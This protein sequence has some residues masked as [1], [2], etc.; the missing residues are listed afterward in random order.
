MAAPAIGGAALGAAA[1]APPLGAGHEPSAL[2]SAMRVHVAEYAV[3][4][5]PMAVVAQLAPG[6]PPAAVA[7]RD[8]LVA[9]AALDQQ[10]EK[11]RRR[12]ELRLL[13]FDSSAEVDIAAVRAALD[14][15]P[16]GALGATG[17]LLGLSFGPIPFARSEQSEEHVADAITAFQKESRAMLGAALVRHRAE[18][19]VRARDLA[20]CAAAGAGAAAEARAADALVVKALE[21]IG[22][23]KGAPAAA[24][25]AAAQAATLAQLAIAVTHLGNEQSLW[26][27]AAS[28]ADNSVVFRAG[29]VELLLTAAGHTA[30]ARAGGGRSGGGAGDT[31]EGA[32][33]SV[34]AGVLDLAR[35][36]EDAIETGRVTLPATPAKWLSVN[37]SS[38]EPT[39]ANVTR[40]AGSTPISQIIPG[41][42]TAAMIFGAKTLQLSG[43]QFT[44][45]RAGRETIA[46][47][48]DAGVA[49][50][51]DA[52]PQAADALMLGDPRVVAEATASVSFTRTSALGAIARSEYPAGGK[53]DISGH[54]RF[55]AQLGVIVDAI[56]ID[57]LRELA[58][59]ANVRAD[60]HEVNKRGLL[61]AASRIAKNLDE[62]TGTAAAAAAAAGVTAP[63]LPPA[64]ALVMVQGALAELLSASYDDA[65]TE[66]GKAFTAAGGGAPGL[67]AAAA[68]GPSGFAALRIN[69]TMA[70]EAARTRGASLQPFLSAYIASATRGGGSAS[71]KRAGGWRPDSAGGR[72]DVFQGVG[73]DGADAAWWARHLSRTFR[74]PGD[75]SDGGGSAAGD[76]GAGAHMLRAVQGGLAVRRPGGGSGGCGVREEP[77]F[78]PHLGGEARSIEGG[79]RVE[80]G[81]VG[82]HGEWA[83]GERGSVSRARPRLPARSRLLSTFVLLAAAASAAGSLADAR[84]G[85]FHA[86]GFAG[87][88]SAGT[89]GAHASDSIPVAGNRAG[90]VPASVH[91]VDAARV[92]DRRTGEPGGAAAR[93]VPARGTCGIPAGS[94]GGIPV[95][96]FV[97]GIPGDGAVGS[98]PASSAT[99]VAGIPCDGAV[100]S[101]PAAS[102]TFVA[103]IPCDGAVGS[104]PASSATFV[105]GIPGD[106]G[107]SDARVA[108]GPPRAGDACV[109]VSVA[110]R[111]ALAAV[112][113]RARP[114]SEVARSIAAQRRR[115]NRHG[116]L[117]VLKF[118]SRDP[119][120]RY[121]LRPIDAPAFVAPAPGEFDAARHDQL[122][123]G[124]VVAAIETVAAR[125]VLSAHDLVC[126]MTAA[127]TWGPTPGARA[128]VKGAVPVA[129][130]LHADVVY[131]MARADPAALPPG[132]SAEMLRDAVS[133]GGDAMYT[134]VRRHATTHNSSPPSA[135]AA[136]Q[137][138]SGHDA[139]VAGGWVLDVTEIVVACPLMPLILS[140]IR[141]VPKAF[142]DDGVTATSWRPISVA[143]GMPG[144]G[145][146]WGV[147]PSALHPVPLD[148]MADVA[149][150]IHRV[151]SSAGGEPV[152]IG[153]FDYAKA[154]RQFA[155]RVDDLWLHC[156]CLD[157]RVYA[158]MRIAF[159]SRAGGQWLCAVTHLV[160]RSVSRELG[161]DGA[162]V[163]FVDDSGIVV[164]ESEFPRAEALFRAAAARVGLTINE[165]KVLPPATRQRFIGP[166]WCTETMRIYLPAAK[167]TLLCSDLEAAAAA[168]TLRCRD[169]LS[170]LQRM[171]WASQ[172]VLVLASCQAPI[173]ALIRAQPMEARLP[174]TPECRE[175]LLACVDM[176]RSCNGSSVV[177][178]AELLAHAPS[179]Y[180]DASTWGFGWM[181]YE[182][183]RYASEP[184]PAGSA[185]AAA[186][187]NALELPAASAAMIDLVTQRAAAGI[188]TPAVHVFCDNTAACACI[189]SLG[190]SSLMLATGTHAL[191]SAA[192]SLDFVPLST[193]VQSAANPADAPSRGEIPLELAG[194]T[195]VR[196]APAAVAQWAAPSAWQCLRS[197]PPA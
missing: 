177:P 29:A 124:G 3:F 153:A 110:D 31:S 89:T 88:V 68:L 43:A 154:Y 164:V 144:V 59:I 181:C 183:R 83:A 184:W 132:L 155:N 36:R 53:G 13:D 119:A 108:G 101:I 99:F 87:L 46:R 92:G 81:A 129:S 113:P 135:A 174:I 32:S 5:V 128:P 120:H 139:D 6:A 143:S 74:A 150:A 140:G 173:R 131:E 84:G 62:S 21:A 125:G 27:V 167:T 175:A 186:H 169:L 156:Y 16:D 106:S 86:S 127:F 76:A 103:G 141:Q 49:R 182:T 115:L 50:Y 82:R 133:H 10:A 176:L 66:C 7:A 79:D 146:N 33:S 1:V 77:A 60:A 170:L 96:P 55:V 148:T 147:D 67:A 158:D 14:L 70:E 4:N 93:G 130:P 196:Y 52:H 80:G 159:G 11:E 54:H 179:T 142:A 193:W 22:V 30:V 24:V 117:A 105:D 107:T 26:A 40:P 28:R 64:L 134:G 151:V 138:R 172:M 39:A 35:V 2:C 95:L 136:A 171:Q 47:D 58:G 97:D 65:L 34:S 42:V 90:G 190:T 102:A 75:R 178:R 111:A 19:L 104:F 18:R 192:A 57:A 15:V 121:E 91:C 63:P 197:S 20:A 37:L 73:P 126:A 161:A 45:G 194:W 98:I 145:S 51:L 8:L 180:S 165:D 118:P 188:P 25:T 168:R 191:A 189:S 48:I 41:A 112:L 23:L 116:H 9:Q 187:I 166:E 56:A 72:D 152:V 71:K 17:V 78:L 61:Q 38:P 123:V 163:C 85:G 137:L 122:D 100:G 195:R 69:P 185:A 94:V 114:A 149:A 44:L 157:G 109:R 162:C 12:H 160:A